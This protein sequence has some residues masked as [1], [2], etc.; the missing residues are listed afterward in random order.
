MCPSMC[1]KNLFYLFIIFTSNVKGT[2]VGVSLSLQNK[3]RLRVVESSK[4]EARI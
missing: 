2:L 3:Q 4:D 1:E